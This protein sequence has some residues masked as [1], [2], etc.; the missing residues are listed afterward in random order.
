[1]KIVAVG[2]NHK[3]APIDI[4]EKLAFDFDQNIDALGKLKDS[5]PEGEFVLLSTCNR[6][7]LYSVS[8]STGG[9]DLEQIAGF[10]SEFH[11]IELND[12]RDYLYVHTNEDAVRH[13]LTVA[14]GLDSMVLGEDQILGQV[15]ESYRFACNAKS[16]GKILNRLFHCAFATSKKVHTNTHVS[17]GRISIAGISVELAI[18][19]FKEI[20]KA[21]TVVI[22]AGEMGELLVK[23]LSHAGCSDITIVNRSYNRG[24]SIAKRRGIKA[25]KWN[26]LTNLLTDADIV[27]ASASSQDY[28]FKKNS[29]QKIMNNR[30]KKPLLI[31]DIAVPRNFEPAIGKIENVHIYSVDELSDVAKENRKARESDISKGMQIIYEGVREFMDWFGAREVGPMIG[32]MKEQFGQISQKELERFFV[33]TRQQASCKEV[34]EAMVNRV[35]SKLLHCVISNVDTVTK[36]HG[37]TEAAKLVDSIVRQ[38]EKISSEHDDKGDENS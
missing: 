22:G 30:K 29:F 1:M 31:I 34:L 27:I 38:A 32:K 35:V 13:L 11:K 2:L 19:L 3:S 28:L 9:I 21:K 6:V 16:T 12:F 18:Q 33:G 25:N 23:H 24:E 4:R 26:E 10:F 37:P 20:S 36:K 5:F 7:E 17:D 8:E 15:K 14:S